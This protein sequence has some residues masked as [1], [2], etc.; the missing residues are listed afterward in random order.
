[1]FV[2]QAEKVLAILIALGSFLITITVNS[3]NVNDP[4]NAPKLLVLG[5]LA[6]G[7]L[8]FVAQNK[9]KFADFSKQKPLNTVG[10]LFLLSALLSIFFSESSIVSGFYGVYGRNTGFLTY[11]CLVV[12]IIV[13]RLLHSTSAMKIVLSGLFY[14]G[15][16][17]LIYFTFTRFGID[18][19][20]WNNG[21]GR[22]LGTFGNPNFV[23]AF[24]GFF[25]ILCSVRAVDKSTPNKWRALLVVLI[26]VAMYEVKLS[27]AVQGI[28]I[29]C[30][31][32]SI[33]GFLYIR[34]HFDSKIFLIAYSTII[35]IIG[36]FAVAGALQKGPLTS[37]I[38]KT[39]VSLRG[40]YW[41]A[42]WQMGLSHPI[43]GVGMDSYGIWYRRMR[44]TS[45]LV[46][47]GPET[48]SDAAHNVF[49]DIFAY[50]GFPLFIAYIL[51][52]S[53]VVFHIWRGF[54][55]FKKFDPTYVSLIAVWI[56]YQA[57]SIISINQIGLAIW[58]WILGGLIIGYVRGYI[59][60][61]EEKN[62]ASPSNPKVKGRNAVNK[63]KS[64]SLWI[65]F[66]GMFIGGAIAAPPVHADS[67]WRDTQMK[68]D[69][70]QIEKNS[71]IWPL[72]ALRVLQA[73]TIYTRNN[74]PA[75]GLEI[76]RYAVDKFPNNFFAWKV[77]SDTPGAT[78]AEKAKA[79]SEMH[80]LDPLNPAFK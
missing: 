50:G 19:F 62:S 79:R 52:N 66:L 68:L 56:C 8:F 22:I 74:V 80:R 53:F 3:W 11:F 67:K 17:N 60:N 43:F 2:N 7:A 20:S 38:Y 1:M 59:R 34:S 78:D 27:L 45:A 58:G 75:K 28:V 21:F 29:V 25:I 24:M 15:V 77:L 71:K 6:G 48:T 18:F 23:G 49:L 36:T 63:S 76:A 73:S 61:E 42:A 72:E 16:V 10:A 14:A 69:P 47:P 5:S 70:A 37:L 30:L 55:L 35:G 57:Q 64:L 44:D 26:L 12:L 31:G 54:K 4:V 33:I 51:I 9:T 65:M 13:S 39:S 40:E 46:L 41:Y 32:W